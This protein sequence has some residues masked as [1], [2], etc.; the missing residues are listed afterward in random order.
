M[1]KAGGS[2]NP[3]SLLRNLVKR[4]LN[5]LLKDKTDTL[6]GI[7]KPEPGKIEEI[8]AWQP[9]L[10]KIDKDVRDLFREELSDTLSFSLTQEI[11]W[12]MLTRVNERHLDHDEYGIKPVLK[13]FSIENSVSP[14]KDVNIEIS[15]VVKGSVILKG[16]YLF[17]GEII[18][19]SPDMLL[20]VA[21]EDVKAIKINK[22]AI[23]LHLIAR[24]GDQEIDL[25]IATVKAMLPWRIEYDVIGVSRAF[26]SQDKPNT[27]AEGALSIG[28]TSSYSGNRQFVCTLYIMG[29]RKDLDQIQY[30]DYMLHPTF[31]KPIIGVADRGGELAFPLELPVYGEFEVKARI[32]F[33]G[34]KVT[35][36]LSHWVRLEAKK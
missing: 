16:D 9:T 28:N 22:I 5:S 32:Y 3:V 26:S 20:E 34:F 19:N 30:V 21:Q 13:H 8:D 36:I 14:I 15:N 24:H 27:G 23:E 17:S 10:T 35:E 6:K 7:M 2:L 31:A 12:V 25:G 33:K 4:E 29:Q 11:F 1:S 18:M